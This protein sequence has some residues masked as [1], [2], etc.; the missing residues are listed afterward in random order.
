MS[1]GANNPDA[2]AD[3]QAQE[4]S[5]RG[6]LWFFPLPPPTTYPN[7]ASATHRRARPPRVQRPRPDEIDAVSPQPSAQ[8]GEHLVTRDKLH[9]SAID[10][11]DATLE[12]PV[13]TPL[14]HR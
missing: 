8:P 5:R 9:F 2:A 7:P 4:E 12:S 10:L 13:A 6:A 3:A 1:A 14:L 11:G